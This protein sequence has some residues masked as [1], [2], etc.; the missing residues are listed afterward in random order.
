MK[1]LAHLGNK[2]LH[3]NKS[4]MVEGGKF[5]RARVMDQT[6][7]DRYLMRGILNLSQHRA[8]E[9]LLG[10]AAKAGAWPT[11]ANWAGAGGGGQHDYVPSAGFSFGGTL[12]CVRDKYGFFHAYVVKE[13]VIHDWDV[14]GDDFRMGVLKQ[15]LDWIGFRRMGAGVDRLKSLRKK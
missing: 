10:Q 3:K 13:V 7:I 5:P 14:S 8:G 12:A 9:M 6:M 15:G 2:M 11:G 1:N 4:V